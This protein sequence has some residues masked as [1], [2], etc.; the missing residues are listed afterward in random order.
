MAG[1]VNYIVNIRSVECEH[2]YL[3]KKNLEKKNL[4]DHRKIKNS[5]FIKLIVNN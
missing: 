5:I 2:K 4:I 3:M 1:I